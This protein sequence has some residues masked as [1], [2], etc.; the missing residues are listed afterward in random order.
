MSEEIERQDLEALLATR[1]ELG[2]DYDR[3]LVQSFADRVERAVEERVSTAVA[4]RTA[5]QAPDT[6]G[7]TFQLVVALVSVVALIPISIVLGLNDHLLALLVAVAGIGAVNTAF[8]AVVG[9][10]D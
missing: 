8:A 10:R 1:R 9:H 3:A 4:R 5:P 2:P 6:L 7:R